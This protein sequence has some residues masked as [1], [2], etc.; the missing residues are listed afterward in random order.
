MVAINERTFQCQ[1][2]GS[3]QARWEKD[4]VG[5]TATCVSCGDVEYLTKSLHIDRTERTDR[6]VGKAARMPTSPSPTSSV[7][8]GPPVPVQAE[9][10]AAEPVAEVPEGSPN[11]ESEDMEKAP[12]QAD[13]GL[14]ENAKAS[15]DEPE[16]PEPGTDTPE[17][18]LTGESEG[19]EKAPEQADEGLSENAKPAV[20]EP[21][22]PVSVSPCDA[23]VL[24]PGTDTPEGSSTGESEGPEK[25]PE[26]SDDGPSEIGETVLQLAEAISGGELSDTP[27]QEVVDAPASRPYRVP[28]ADRERLG[29]CSVC[30]LEWARENFKTCEKC[31]AKSRESFRKRYYEKKN[32]LE[33][34]ES[35]QLTS[36]KLSSPTPPNALMMITSWV[37][38]LTAQQPYD[39]MTTGGLSP[40]VTYSAEQIVVEYLTG[41]AELHEGVLALIPKESVTTLRVQLEAIK[42]VIAIIPDKNDSM[43]R[44]MRETGKIT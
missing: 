30:G 10:E 24:E 21:D 37:A 7:V 23:E 36:M 19:S 6:T 18:S 20:D 16:V 34:A 4:Q 9:T 17:G 41:L 39:E 12:E 43:G 31:A 1:K 28:K 40:G 44:A 2:C 35:Q 3:M 32:E 22:E 13:E 14:S 29:I 27:E 42:L 25:A 5:F 26:N 38:P 8:Y 11:V 15:V 33:L